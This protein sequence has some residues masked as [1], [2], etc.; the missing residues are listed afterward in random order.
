ME[1]ES[2]EPTVASSSSVGLLREEDG[3]GAIFTFVVRVY[4]MW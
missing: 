2:E 4:K 1:A 3:R